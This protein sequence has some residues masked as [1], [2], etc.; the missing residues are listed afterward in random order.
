MNMVSSCDDGRESF[1]V[2]VFIF[3]C[4]RLIVSRIVC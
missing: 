3:F 4:W 2:I 1:L